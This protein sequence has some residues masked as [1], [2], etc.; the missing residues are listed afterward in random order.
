MGKKETVY[1]I[2]FL[3]F[4][5]ALLGALFVWPKN[6]N[7]PFLPKKEYKLGLDLKGGVRLLYQADLSGIPENERESVMLGLKD[8]I[9][10]RINIFGVREPRIQVQGEKLIVELAGVYDPKKAIE[11]IGKT[12]FLEFREE[13]DEKEREKLLS[14]LKDKLKERLS[15]KEWEDLEKV[16]EQFPFLFVEKAKELKIDFEDPF[17]KK[18]PLT[19]RYLKGAKVDFNPTTF[20]PVVSLQFNEKGAKIFEKLTEKNVGK[21]LAIY[22]DGVLISSPVVKEKISG[23][24]ALIEGN[25]TAKEAEKLASNLNAGAL[26]VPISLSSQDVIGPTLGKVCLEKSLKAGIFGLLAIFIFMILFYRMLGL[27]ANLALIIYVI[28]VLAIFKLIGVTLTLAGIGGFILSIGMAIDAN[29]LIFSR[30]REE[31]NLKKSFSQSLKEGF[32]RAWPAIRDGNFTTLLVS[33]ILFS[34]GTSFVKGFA[35]TLS[36]GILTSLFTALVVT[37]YFLKCFEGTKLEKIIW[38]WK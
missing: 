31:M 38:L 20:E 18:T 10:R 26:P 25:F 29:I 16:G 30:M 36:I 9:E 37:K 12:P 24:R 6:F 15:Q 21:R 33:L 28:F 22:I 17:F 13:R 19:G 8:V 34:F 4:I 35:T 5:L 3:I 1:L 32:S 23:G 27:I 14:Q 7:F 2:V 11:E